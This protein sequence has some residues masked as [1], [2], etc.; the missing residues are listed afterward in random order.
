MHINAQAL[1]LLSGVV[2]PLALGIITKI[3]AS[4]RLQSFLNAVPA[5][6]LNWKIN[7]FPAPLVWPDCARK[8]S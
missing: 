8:L 6:L 5:R 2:I 1:A 7:T 4:R 3:T